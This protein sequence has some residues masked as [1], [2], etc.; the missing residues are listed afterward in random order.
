MIVLS[1]AR[2]SV[3]KSSS[4]GRRLEKQRNEAFVMDTLVPLISPDYEEKISDKPVGSGLVEQNLKPDRE[5][6]K[7]SQTE[8]E[9][10]KMSSMF[11]FDL[12]SNKNFIFII[13]GVA[14][15]ALLMNRGGD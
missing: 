15:L 8:D 6:E 12:L 5:I 13:S 9:T 7:L 14:V 3:Q 10:P 4:A 1:G 11:N 2:R